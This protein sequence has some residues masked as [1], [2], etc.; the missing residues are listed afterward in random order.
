MTAPAEMSRF[1]RIL[2]Y[3]IGIVRLIGGLYTTIRPACGV[4][5]HAEPIPLFVWIWAILFGLV[6]RYAWERSWPAGVV[7]GI[8]GS[9]ASLERSSN[10]SDFGALS[11][12]MARTCTMRT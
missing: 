3:L 4:H 11:S 10:P 12:E 2:L 8:G 1:T 6:G 5:D 7:A 9:M